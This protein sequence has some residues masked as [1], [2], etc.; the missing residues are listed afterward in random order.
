[1]ATKR[2]KHLLSLRER[3]RVIAAYQALS[4]EAQRAIDAMIA[5]LPQRPPRATR[6]GTRRV[7]AV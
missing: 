4:P 7:K 1:M 5:T 6:K 3:Q 2:P